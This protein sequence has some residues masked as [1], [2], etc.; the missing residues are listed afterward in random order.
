MKF[1]DPVKRPALFHRFDLETHEPVSV[2]KKINV[3]NCLV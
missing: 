2:D 3:F 1:V